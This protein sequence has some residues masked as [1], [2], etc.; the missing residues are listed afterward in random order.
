ME[1]EEP[2]DA[3]GAGDEAK[4]WYSQPA[5]WIL[6]A[7]ALAALVVVIVVVANNGDDGSE[8]ATE[9]PTEEPTEEPTEGP[10]E[11]FEVA[12]SG[13]TAP[14]SAYGDSPPTRC[15]SRTTQYLPDDA[16][17]VTC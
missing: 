16:T 1:P 12:A 6:G 4:S 10:S 9:N 13:V 5:A 15:R 2:A 14:M 8:V 3:D 7:V 17:E 11:L